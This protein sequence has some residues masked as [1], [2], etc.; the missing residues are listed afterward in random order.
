MNYTEKNK[1]IDS[2]CGV[3]LMLLLVEIF[4]GIVESAFTTFN[5]N[6]ANVTMYTQIAGAVFLLIAIIVLI[7][8]YKKDNVTNAIYGIELIV[9][10]LS[11]ALLPGSYLDFVFPFNKL[12]VV[13]PFAFLAYYV[14]KTVVVI[15]KANKKANKA[16]GNKK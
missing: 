6:Y 9:L 16:K 5:Y 15:V 3:G 11:A 13:F 7:R 2:L 1:L 10:A 12:N 4:Y 14:I 8:A